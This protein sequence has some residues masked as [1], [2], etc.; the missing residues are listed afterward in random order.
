MKKNLKKIIP[1]QIW[2]LREKVFIKRRHIKYRIMGHPFKLGETAKARGRRIEEGFFEKYCQGKGLD[3]GYGG[4]ILAK[5]CRGWDVEHGNAQLLKGIKDS[6]FDFVYSSHTLEHMVEPETA[7]KNWWRV[8]KS[9]G[10]LIIYVPHRDLYEKKKILPSKWNQ[11]HKHFFLLNNDEYPDTIGIV[12]LI[13][14][15]ISQYK[16]IYAKECKDGH[17]VEDAEVHSNGE[18]SI[19]IV[20]KKVCCRYECHC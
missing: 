16:I 9:G 14:R 6:K 1:R 8:L 19:E 2:K 11:D 10:Y 15:T 4:D 17:T 18:Y 5:N 7:L 20:I 13:Q 12:P 3:I